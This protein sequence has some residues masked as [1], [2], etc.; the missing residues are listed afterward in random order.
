MAHC[1]PKCSLGA[2]PLFAHDEVGRAGESFPLMCKSSLAPRLP[3][4]H[5]VNI[6]VDMTDYDIDINIMLYF[7]KFLYIAFIDTLEVRA[8]LLAVT[9]Y[10]TLIQCRI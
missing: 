4:C 10:N 3:L 6:N 2:T 5:I 8:K 9:H 1:G 7:H